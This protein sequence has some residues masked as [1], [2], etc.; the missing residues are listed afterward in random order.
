VFGWLAAY[1]P[2]WADA[3]LHEYNGY[4]LAGYV[5]I[6]LLGSIILTTLI[7]VS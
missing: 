7:F 6:E 2:I 5:Q 4:W 1:I 3:N